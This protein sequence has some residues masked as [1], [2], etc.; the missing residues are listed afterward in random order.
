MVCEESD[1]ISTLGFFVKVKW[2]SIY[3]AP[4]ELP[5]LQKM[6]ARKK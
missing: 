1:Y 6:Q 4:T 5:N 3:K 2:D